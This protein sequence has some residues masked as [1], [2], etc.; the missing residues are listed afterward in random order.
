[1][2]NPS[3]DDQQEL[4]IAIGGRKSLKSLEVDVNAPTCIL[5]GLGNILLKS[6]SRF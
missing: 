6:C 2:E 4:G 5:Q 3:L 1:M